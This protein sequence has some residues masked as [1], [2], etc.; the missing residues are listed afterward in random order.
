MS[1]IISKPGWAFCVEVDGADLVVRN[2]TATWFGG[3]NDPHDIGGHTA[4]GINTIQAPNFLGC[5][6]PVAWWS[7]STKD[8]PFIFK[9]GGVK[10]PSIPYQTVVRVE[11]LGKTLDVR[12]IDNG[13]AQSAKDGIDLTVAAFRFFAPLKRGVIKGVTYRV[14]GA[15]K[16]AG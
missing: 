9:S 2:T 8:S 5:A 14:L 16:Y 15:A 11:A 7:R 12:L 6:L 4:S 10:K 3:E 1:R 13:P